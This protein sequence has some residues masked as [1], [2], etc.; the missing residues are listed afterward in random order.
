[1]DPLLHPKYL[2]L[3]LEQ[4]ERSLKGH[5]RLFLVVASLTAYPE[6]VLC[7]FNDGSLKSCAEHSHPRIVLE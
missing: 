4:R 3:L 7:A 1:M 2:L 5:T 6:N